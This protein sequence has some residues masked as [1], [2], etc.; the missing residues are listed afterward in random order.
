MSLG[1]F[2]RR[3][4]GDKYFHVAFGMNATNDHTRNLVLDPLAQQAEAFRG[5]PTD[6][7]TLVVPGGSCVAFTGLLLGLAKSKIRFKR[8]VSVQIAGYDRTSKIEAMIAGRDVPPYEHIV[9]H[10][11]PYSRKVKRAVGG[12]VLDSGYEAKAWAWV[13]RELPTERVLFYVVGNSN[14]TRVR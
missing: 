6:T 3:R 7:M 8:I 13:E 9:D 11:Y 14:I 2:A 12:V 1:A 4:Y 10:T 5:L